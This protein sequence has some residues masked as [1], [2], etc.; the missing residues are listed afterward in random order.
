[1]IKE[2]FNLSDDED[3]MLK[4]VYRRTLSLSATYN[5][6]RMQGLGYVFSMIPVINRFYQTKEKRIAAYKR[7]FELFNTTPTMGGFITGL[8]SAMEKE[9]SKDDNFDT[10]TINA[11]KVS[12]MGPF[13][14]IGDTIF[15]AA[16]RIISLGIG[17]SLCLNGN[18][19]GILLHLLI[20]NAIAHIPRYYGVY[21]GY[22][23]G[24]N[25]IRNAIKQG[26]LGYLTKAAG[27]VG[28]VTVGAM[29]CQMVSFNIAWIPDIQGSPL[30]IQETLDSIFPYLLPLLLTFG[31]FKFISKGV[32]PIWLMLGLMVIGMIGKGIGIF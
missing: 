4:S 31:C 29:T 17:I 26:T 14:G 32:K 12:L 8:S 27:I 11:V 22:G 3:K 24:S 18:P 7:H 23:L 10:T 16:L 30:N 15:W 25:F 13:A 1:M 6:E 20:F 21:Y 9:A 2:K 5:Y 28:L 19:L